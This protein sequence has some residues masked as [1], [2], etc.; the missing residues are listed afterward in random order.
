MTL[1]SAPHSDIDEN[2]PTELFQIMEDL[3]S[4]DPLKYK[5]VKLLDTDSEDPKPTFPFRSIQFNVIRGDNGSFVVSMNMWVDGG[6][7]YADHT[8]VLTPSEAVLPVPLYDVRTSVGE[9]R[10]P[11]INDALELLVE[12]YKAGKVRDISLNGR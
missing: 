10:T 11:I 3:A 8:V 9:G 1:D 12:G 6:S 4:D 7:E 5:V 2:P